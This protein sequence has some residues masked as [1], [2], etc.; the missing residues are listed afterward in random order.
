M[1]QL[2]WITESL[3]WLLRNIL[4]N[5]SY[6]S[7]IVMCTVESK[8]NT[9]ILPVWWNEEFFLVPYPTDMILQISVSRNI[10]E[11]WRHWHGYDWSRL[12]KNDNT[13]IFNLVIVKKTGQIVQNKMSVIF[14]SNNGFEYHL[15]SNPSLRLTDMSARKFHMPLKSVICLLSDSLGK[16]IPADKTF[17]TLSNT[18][19]AI[20]EYMLFTSF[21]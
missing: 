13:Y 15:F 8:H 7:C 17:G 11:T 19:T 4:I 2:K 14:T 1:S 9:P 20:A 3:F 16:S 18:T 6:R 12:H 5:Y 10:I 21:N